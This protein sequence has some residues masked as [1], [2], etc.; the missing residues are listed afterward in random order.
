MLNKTFPILLRPQSH[1]S[2]P[3]HDFIFHKLAHWGAGTSAS[4]QTHHPHGHPETSLSSPILSGSSDLPR[5][6][7]CSEGRWESCPQTS[8]KRGHICLTSMSLIGTRVGP[9]NHQ[10]LGLFL[11]IRHRLRFLDATQPLT[12]PKSITRDPLC[13][14]ERSKPLGLLLSLHLF[15]RDF[16]TKSNQIV[17]LKPN[18][19]LDKCTTYLISHSSATSVNHTCCF[20]SAPLCSATLALHATCTT[21]QEIGWCNLWCRRR[22][23]FWASAC[24]S[25]CEVL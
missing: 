22:Y 13:M 20:C 25:I 8:C 12:L 15:P 7:F 24:L 14:G 3:R 10:D 2:K 17:C 4:G 9:K 6:T 18:L 23:V 11:E 1:F 21:V 5:H 16:S 19:S